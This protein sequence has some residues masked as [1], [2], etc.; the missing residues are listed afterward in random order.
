MKDIEAFMHDPITSDDQYNEAL[1][2]VDLLF[3]AGRGTVEA[4]LRDKLVQ[5]IEAY[6]NEQYPIGEPSARALGELRKE[7]G[8][9]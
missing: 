1:E 9:E 4:E 8:V 7:Q 6:E 5:Q 2:T 3:H